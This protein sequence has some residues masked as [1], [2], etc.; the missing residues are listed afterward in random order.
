MH[1]KLSTG[2]RPDA[3]R[4]SGDQRLLR[5]CFRLGR[6]TVFL[7]LL[8]VACLGSVALSA[9]PDTLK[10]QRDTIAAN[11]RYRVVLVSHSDW[12]L[13]LEVLEGRKLLWKT[14]PSSTRVRVALDRNRIVIFNKTQNPGR[15]N[16]GKAGATLGARMFTLTGE[17]VGDLP[18]SVF[19]GVFLES[20]FLAGTVRRGMIAYDLKT[21]K[22]LWRN[23]KLRFDQVSLAQP[24][25]LNLRWYDRKKKEFRNY[26]V[27][28]DSGK[29]L[30]HF[31][32]P[33]N[34]YVK[35][36]AASE[37]QLVTL[38]TISKGPGRAVWQSEVLAKDGRKI[39]QIHWQGMPI[40]ACFSKDM[41]KL[42]VV[43]VSRDEKNKKVVHYTA[44]VRTVEGKL[45]QQRKLLTSDLNSYFQADILFDSHSLHITLTKKTT[46]QLK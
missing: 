4:S 40:K 12:T 15:M 8:L 22:E 35:F 31:S 37:E 3:M 32:G 19:D 43:C 18:A 6:R 26:L 17:E 44:D 33:E 28:E 23:K 5:A 14:Q 39:T 36:L 10:E 25:I 2:K 13:G 16:E 30:R 7:P 20:I 29:I 34:E 1:K 11:D 45:I 24:G 46:I 42:A 27:R 41:R 38:T 9:G 21:V